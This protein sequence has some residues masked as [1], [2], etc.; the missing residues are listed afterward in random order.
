MKNKI[1]A[2]MIAAVAFCATSCND[3]LDR[4]PQ[5]ANSDAT[6]WTS[7]SSLKTA[8]WALYS[9]FDSYSYGSGWTRGQYHGESLTDDY[10]SDSYSYSTTTIPSSS[11]AW[12]GPYT[13]IR[14]ANILL[15]RV[16][17]VPGLSATA[18]K[19]WKGIAR[20]FRG[21]EHFELVRSYGDVVWV[22][23]EINIDDAEALGRGR[24]PRANVMDSVCNDLKFAAENCYSPSEADNNTVNSMVAYALLSRAALYE[25]AWQKYHEN[26]K[27]LA[28]KYYEIAKDAAKQI[29]SSGLYNIN[30]TY[31]S[32]YTSQSLAG[33]TEM[34]L[35]DT[36][37][38][39]GSGDGEVNKGN[40][41]VGWDISSSPSWGLTKSAV[42][43]YTDING[44][45]TYMSAYSDATVEDV[46]KNR[47][48][49]LSQTADAAL[50]CPVGFSYI[51][52]IVSS[53]GYWVNK[54]VPWERK[55][56]MQNTATWN[57]PSNDIDGPIF[58]Y[59][60]VLEN[61][62]EASA[63]VADLGGA[64]ITQSDLDISVNVLRVKHGNIPVLTLVGTTG[65]AVNG[66]TI[67]LDPKNTKTTG[68]ISNLLWELRRDRRSE[69]MCDGFRYNDLMRWALG[70][71]LDFAFNPDGYL[72]ASRAAIEAFY[73]AHKSDKLYQTTSGADAPWA[74]IETG[75]YWKN[76]YKSPYELT[77]V[78]VWDNKNYLEPIPSGQ[79][80][81]DPSLAPQNPGW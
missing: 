63:E 50:L 16:N 72:G 29:I 51:D 57:A 46:F 20:F 48:K 25:G 71:N 60:E 17:V 31:K 32:N 58:A 78:R 8:A 13:E 41:I 67:T 23:A 5:D 18:A 21:M 53:T 73:N 12:S 11:S 47:D 75:N 49:R 79:I 19:H 59:P 39:I 54:F 2:L 74:P 6:N 61:Y 52:G 43:N 55:E 81:L 22:N 10:C 33:N 35:Y 76:N 3:Y 64:A 45:P 62:A 44:L 28:L 65:V 38:Q 42:E 26:N 66:V 69:L 40:S 7:E 34:I 15:N 30:T 68:G 14:R 36:Y 1:F 9:N 27:T 4:Y 77:Q 80:T 70:K 37:C 56:E 24:D